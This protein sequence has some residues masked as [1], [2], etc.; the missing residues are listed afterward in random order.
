M[1]AFKLFEEISKLIDSDKA[2]DVAVFK[3]SIRRTCKEFIVKMSCIMV[4]LSERKVKKGVGFAKKGRK[5]FQDDL[6]FEVAKSTNKLWRFRKKHGEISNRIAFF[7][8]TTPSRNCHIWG[9]VEADSSSG[10]EIELSLDITGRMHL[11]K[12]KFEEGDEKL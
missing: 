2:S 3:A 8:Y 12:I 1:V 6:T 7:S 10:G 5:E 11:G 9:Y 4:G